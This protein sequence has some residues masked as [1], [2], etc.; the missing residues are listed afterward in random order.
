MPGIT[1]SS[2]VPHA[3]GIG[4]IHGDVPSTTLEISPVEKTQVT[5]DN[6]R[7]MEWQNKV[8]KRLSDSNFV[9]GTLRTK[10]DFMQMQD[11][12]AAQTNQP[13]SSLGRTKYGVVTPLPDDGGVAVMTKTETKPISA[14]PQTNAP[15]V[16]PKTTNQVARG[17]Y[18][19]NMTQGA[20]AMAVLGVGY[21]AVTGGDVGSAIAGGLGGVAAVAAVSGSVA[22]LA[23]TSPAWVPAVI[24]GAAGMAGGLAA[25]WAYGA[26]AESLGF[27][28]QNPGLGTQGNPTIIINQGQAGQAGQTGQVAGVNYIIT[29]QYREQGITKTSQANGSF[30]GPIVEGTRYYMDYSEQLW[31]RYGGVNTDRLSFGGSYSGRTQITFTCTRSDGTPALIDSQQAPNYRPTIPTESI[32]NNI[33]NVTNVINNNY[34][35]N[36]T[37]SPSPSAPQPTITVPNPTGQIAQQSTIKTSNGTVL[38]V[39]NY[40]NGTL[41]VQ[42]QDGSPVSVGKGSPGAEALKEFI[43][44]KGHISPNNSP[45]LQGKPQFYNGN[46]PSNIP[47]MPGLPQGQS[48]TKEAVTQEPKVINGETIPTVAQ[49]LKPQS[50]PKYNQNQTLTPEA[51]EQKPKVID[52]ETIQPVAQSINQQVQ[53][54]YNRVNTDNPPVQFPQIDPVTGSFKPVVNSKFGELD[55]KTGLLKPN[56]ND[57][58]NSSLNTIDKVQNKPKDSAPVGTNPAN[59][60]DSQLSTIIKNQ[61]GTTTDLAST[62]AIL[63][64]LGTVT[65]L[66]N[67][68]AAVG[69]A[70]QNQPQSSCQ[71]SPGQPATV[72]ANQATTNTTLNV[73]NTTVGGVLLDTT[74]AIKTSIGTPIA[75]GVSTVFGAVEKVQSFGEK[76]AKSLHL[77]KVYNMLT[78]LVVI[79]NGAMLSRSFG[80]T[81]EELLTTGL[82]AAGLKDENG[83]PFDVSGVLEK[84]VSNF[85]KSI[86]GESIYN[87]VS[88]AWKKGSA[89]VTASANIA[90]AV[91][92]PLSGLASGLTAVGNNTGKI[93]NALVKSGAVLENS[94][95][96]MSENVQ[97][98]TGRLAAMD[99]YFTGVT[100]ANELVESVT[101]L[102]RVPIDTKASFDSAKEELKTLDDTMKLE[103]ETKKAADATAKTASQ[104][105]AITRTDLVKP[106]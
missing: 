96:K 58:V 29:W 102:T 62:V 26:I 90:E 84:T 52:G 63:G 70:L 75:G 27:K 3:S 37:Q 78:L 16:T 85:I 55:P 33:T 72:L 6:E 9:E 21:A 53:P 7:A 25:Q 67:K 94:Y 42:S 48:L 28:P 83:N 40:S 99:N 60:L 15:E 82:E 92:S 103:I 88:L 24:V 47:S 81:V 64:T 65:Y 80:S 69:T 100:N 11:M 89:I 19:S 10:P 50:Q 46:N 105:A 35:Q 54:K 93:G 87:G 17:S 106:E 95:E 61:G 66:D 8:G 76:F 45:L 23:A 31:I 39:I 73:V 56:P 77:D 98:K 104:G 2:Y 14:A 38:N 43:E 71:W 49:S 4:G 57:P 86:V 36:I 32:T 30:P 18:T 74:T 97:V 12:K 51:L 13:T 1:S 59:T 34:R 5:I 20:G 79:H 91:I 41:Q 22:G 44:T 101:E 68:F